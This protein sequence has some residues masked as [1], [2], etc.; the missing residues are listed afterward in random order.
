MRQSLRNEIALV[1]R[2]VKDRQDALGA[3]TQAHGAALRGLAARLDVLEALAGLDAVSRWIAQAEL[4]TA[5]LISVV[6]PTRNRPERLRRAIGSVCAQTYTNWEMLVVDDGGADDAAAVVSE[7]R[8]PRVRWTR[9][10]PRGVCAA[11]NHALDMA[12]GSLV[13]YL[14]DDNTLDPGWLKA[15]A[16]VFETRPECSVLYGSVLIDDVSRINGGEPGA[17]PRLFFRPYDR[18]T[19]LEENLADVGAIAHRAGIPEARFDERLSAYGDWD[20]LIRLTEDAAPLALP[21]IATYYT[22]DAPDRLL[23][24][25]LSKDAEILAATH[26]CRITRSD[27]A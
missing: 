23:A 14:D 17:L 2:Q 4:D 24:G 25:D 18:A 1:R 11:R 5:P 10:E 19:L 3:E 6:T 8:D 9:I 16:W 22:T 7:V 15:V 12:H 21:V 27:G 26:G 20:L 13:A